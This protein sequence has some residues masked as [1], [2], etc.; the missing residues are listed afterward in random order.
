MM[1]AVVA[2]AVGVGA[3]QGGSVATLGRL[4]SP[5]PAGPTSHVPLTFISPAF[6]LAGTSSHPWLLA[7]PEETSP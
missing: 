1:V 7:T 3:G 2:V 5:G 6:S 4:Y